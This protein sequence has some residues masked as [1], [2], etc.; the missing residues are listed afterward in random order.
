MRHKTIWIL[1]HRA[2]RSN[3]LIKMVCLCMY[4]FACACDVKN[5]NLFLFYQYAPAF[6]YIFSALFFPLQMSP[7]D[8]FSFARTSHNFTIYISHL[9]GDMRWQWRLWL[10]NIHNNHQQASYHFDAIILEHTMQIFRIFHRYKFLIHKLCTCMRA[11]I[12][13][14]LYLNKL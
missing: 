2:L 1:K 6:I 11:I 10:K 12:C 9:C 7:V 3:K 14:Y 8:G 4:V 5:V 13:M